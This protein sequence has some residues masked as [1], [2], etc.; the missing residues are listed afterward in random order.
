VAVSLFLLFF[1]EF[2]IFW[3]F[4]FILVCVLTLVG[5]GIV[6]MPLI[7][8]L[9]YIG[10]VG[11]LIVASLI[12]VGG[13]SRQVRGGVEAFNWLPLFLIGLVFILVSQFNWFSQLPHRPQ[14]VFSATSE[15]VLIQKYLFFSPDILSF[16]ILFDGFCWAL[17][18]IGI[19]LLMAAV[20]CSLILS[21]I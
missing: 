20:L 8:I 4:L 17:V 2:V 13:G 6:M 9:I 15:Q 14:P 19:F 10:V 1:Y 11:V 18:L 21:T 12:V 5:F 7:I 16:F 3:F